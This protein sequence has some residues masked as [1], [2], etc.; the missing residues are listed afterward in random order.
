MDQNLIH[1]TYDFFPIFAMITLI[2]YIVQFLDKNT[3]IEFFLRDNWAL[4]DLI[5]FTF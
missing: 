3:V 2:E 4:I 1:L 5:L